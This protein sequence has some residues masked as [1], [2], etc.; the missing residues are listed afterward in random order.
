M[1]K[2]EIQKLQAH[3]RRSFG[4]PTLKVTPSSKS[5]EAADVQ[6]GERR[7]GSIVVDDEDGDR[8]FSFEMKIPVERHVL[9]DYLRRLFENDQLTIASRLKKTDSVELNHGPDFLGVIS[10]DDPKGKTYTLQM[11]ILDFDLEDL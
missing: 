7:I 4:A 9:Q 11:A 3:L 6:F 10:A 5:S 8:S 1:D 2:S